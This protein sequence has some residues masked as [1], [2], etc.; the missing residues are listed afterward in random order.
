MAYRSV[1]APGPARAT[2]ALLGVELAQGV[3]GFVQYFTHLPVVLVALHLAGACLVLVAA[4]RMVL[5]TR[6][7][8]PA[9]L[10]PAVAVVPARLVVSAG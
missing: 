4:V 7:R 9:A 8:G 1:G 6:D 3:L 2:A 10:P 5:S